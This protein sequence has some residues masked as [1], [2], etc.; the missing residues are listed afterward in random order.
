MCWVDVVGCLCD[1]CV[2]CGLYCLVFGV[3]VGFSVGVV[4]VGIWVVG[5]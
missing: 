5:Y 3:V 2:D 4:L 1:V